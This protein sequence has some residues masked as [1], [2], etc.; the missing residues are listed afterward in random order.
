MTFSDSDWA[1]AGTEE[2]RSRSGTHVTLF[3]G[4]VD[5]KSKVQS[6]TALSSTEVEYYASIQSAKSAIHQRFILHEIQFGKMLDPEE[7]LN[8]QLALVMMNNQSAMKQ[9]DSFDIREA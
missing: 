1:G 2:R 5:W 7:E 9:A 8:L 6:T 4:A 3:G